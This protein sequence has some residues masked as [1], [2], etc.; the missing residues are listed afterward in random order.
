MWRD[1]A[2]EEHEP[3]SAQTKDGMAGI[4]LNGYSVSSGADLLRFKKAHNKYA[5]AANKVRDGG[6]GSKSNGVTKF[7][8]TLSPILKK[9][10]NLQY[11][12]AKS[13]CFAS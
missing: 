9:G 7:Q 2:E 5:A 10:R 4:D 1:A 6:D 8:I 11:G 12:K 3:P 13:V